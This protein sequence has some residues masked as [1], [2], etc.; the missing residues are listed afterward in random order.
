[1]ICFILIFRLVNLGSTNQNQYF[2]K[3]SAVGVITSRGHARGISTI[4]SLNPSKKLIDLQLPSKEVLAQKFAETVTP[5]SDFFKK[6]NLLL[7]NNDKNENSSLDNN[8]K[9]ENDEN[10]RY[11]VCLEYEVYAGKNDDAT[12]FKGDVDVTTENPKVLLENFS[13]VSSRLKNDSVYSSNENN[14]M[15]I[16]EVTVWGIHGLI[17]DFFAKK[18]AK[19]TYDEIR[20]FVCKKMNVEFIDI[21]EDLNKLVESGDVVRYKNNTYQ[22]I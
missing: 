22:R 9:G 3:F 2:A 4:Y 14:S 7:L 13:P 10:L 11:D 21:N 5:Y 1:L 17:K 16:S 8:N 6:N 20:E 19:I 18:T 12:N 15:G